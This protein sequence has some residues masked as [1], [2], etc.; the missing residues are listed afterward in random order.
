MTLLRFTHVGEPSSHRLVMTIKQD[1]EEAAH[2]KG[3]STVSASANGEN[4]SAAAAATVSC[5]EGAALPPIGEKPE[6]HAGGSEVGE[7]DDKRYRSL[8]YFYAFSEHTIL[9]LRRS[10][11]AFHFIAFVCELLRQASCLP[12]DTASAQE[13][14]SEERRFMYDGSASP[15]SDERVWPFVRLAVGLVDEMS[16]DL[17]GFLR[18]ETEERHRLRHCEGET[19]PTGSM[20]EGAEVVL[21]VGA[22]L[23]FLR[24]LDTYDP[25]R[26]ERRLQPHPSFPSMSSPSSLTSAAPNVFDDAVQIPHRH[27][28]RVLLQVPQHWG[29]VTPLATPADTPRVRLQNISSV[30][31]Y[32]STSAEFDSLFGPFDTSMEAH[33]CLS[34][35]FGADRPLITDVW[36]PLTALQSQQHR[37]DKCVKRLLFEALMRCLVRDRES[38]ATTR[39]RF[40]ALG[41]RDL[42]CV[43]QTCL[44]GDTWNTMGNDGHNYQVGDARRRS[45]EAEAVSALELLTDMLPSATA[46]DIHDIIV[47]LLP[48]PSAGA[49]RD[50]DDGGASYAPFHGEFTEVR[51]FLA[52]VAVVIG[53]DTERFPPPV[54]YDIILRLHEPH[55][56]VAPAAAR[57]MLTNL[58]A[59]DDAIKQQPP[60]ENEDEAEASAEAEEGDGDQVLEE[61]AGGPSRQRC[62]TA[63]VALLRSIVSSASSSS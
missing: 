25:L 34:N 21:N 43:A 14:A 38:L 9:C 20:E 6:E 32:C 49:R 36:L 45:R 11:G 17:G 3:K 15:L 52:H 40:A 55:R 4:V 30:F 63:T 26:H 22:V 7:A 10:L 16:A 23:E 47:V 48:P 58:H 42:A 54:L 35:I 8:A 60:L 12:P 5:R 2:R 28:Y 59:G 18:R 33:R 39:A 1:R 19:A 46:E 37:I 56:L 51:R 27:L 41:P 29:E 57:M 62:Y 61:T 53:N 24:L 31:D 50:G 44:R 13:S